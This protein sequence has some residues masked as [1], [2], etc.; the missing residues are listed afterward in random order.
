[1]ENEKVDKGMLFITGAGCRRH[2]PLLR[3]GRGCVM[4]LLSRLCRQKRVQGTGCKVQE[5][6]C[7]CMM[8]SFS[9]RHASLS[10]IHCPLLIV[11]SNNTPP[12]PSQ[13]GNVTS[14]SQACYKWRAQRSGKPVY[15]IYFVCLSIDVDSFYREHLK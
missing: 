15:V 8:N 14:T 11:N 13:E 3:G 10:I 12:T 9:T 5:S 1:M 7:I 6:I 2:L 4:P